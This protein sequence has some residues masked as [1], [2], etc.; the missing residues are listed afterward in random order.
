MGLGRETDSGGV[1]HS[2]FV[3]LG[4]DP[5]EGRLEDD[6]TFGVSDYVRAPLSDHESRP[7]IPT[8]NVR[9]NVIRSITTMHVQ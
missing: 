1:Q 9:R 4:W 2:L 5:A 7:V 8:L 3:G 6:P